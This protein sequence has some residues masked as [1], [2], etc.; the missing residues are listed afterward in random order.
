MKI[1][2]KHQ[3]ILLLLPCSST[4]FCPILSLSDSIIILK[5][6]QRVRESEYLHT[7]SSI[8]TKYF[9]HSAIINFTLIYQNPR[10]FRSMHISIYVWVLLYAN[11]IA[12]SQL[13]SDPH[14]STWIE[15]ECCLSAIFLHF[16]FFFI[17]VA[18]S[19]A[20]VIVKILR[21]KTHSTNKESAE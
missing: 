16:L 1:N 4:V 15:C 6:R 17:A 20:A 9:I 18:I 3:T 7:I 10:T 5:R 2:A 21:T 19:L 14:G 11:A 8:Y 12:H 13:A